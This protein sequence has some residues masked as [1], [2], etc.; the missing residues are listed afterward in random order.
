MCLTINYKPTTNSCSGILYLTQINLIH[1]ILRCLIQYFLLAAIPTLWNHLDYSSSL[2]SDNCL[3]GNRWWTLANRASL[4]TYRPPSPPLPWRP[5]PPPW[6]PLV[7]VATDIIRSA[8]ACVILQSYVVTQA[9][10]FWKIHFIDTN[11]TVEF[12]SCQWHFKRASFIILSVGAQRWNCFDS[13]LGP[14][15]IYFNHVRSRVV[16]CFHCSA[17]N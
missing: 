11:W 7:R 13:F 3:H 16:S 6:H 10:C 2:R 8:A 5:P 12:V 9:S 1:F 14:S 17:R 4:V 15:F